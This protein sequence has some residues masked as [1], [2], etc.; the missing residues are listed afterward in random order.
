MTTTTLA[1]SERQPAFLSNEELKAND[2][3]LF[4]F[5]TDSEDED[6]EDEEADGETQERPAK[7]QRR[8][9]PISDRTIEIPCS[10]TLKRADKINLTVLRATGNGEGLQKRN[11]CGA[12]TGEGEEA[13]R[14]I[15][16]C[17]RNILEYDYDMWF[18]DTEDF[19][20]VET[21]FTSYY[22]VWTEIF[23]ESDE[24]I[25]LKGRDVLIKELRNFGQSARDV[26]EYNFKWFE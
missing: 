6:E 17:T 4:D 12:E 22:K 7:R 23:K 11:R 15:L 25:G 16:C 21:I 24:T 1:A 19:K 13:P 5:N 10:M 9:K 3:V 14:R 18:R 20:C 8:E 2:R 26:Y